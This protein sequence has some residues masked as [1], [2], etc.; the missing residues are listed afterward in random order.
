MH[1]VKGTPKSWSIWLGVLVLAS[2]ACVGADRPTACEA[3]KADWNAVA[4]RF[5]AT[6]SEFAAYIRAEPDTGREGALPV[7]AYARLMDQVIE[8]AAM[9]PPPPESLSDA[10]EFGLESLRQ[11][12][13]GVRSV[14]EGIEAASQERVAW[15]TDLI[16]QG[17]SLAAQ[18]AGLAVCEDLP[19]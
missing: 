16:E 8:E 4:D 2:T 7:Y 1:L 19:G 18:A 13:A 17:R 9:L 5:D 11:V 15:G 14:G 6:Y 10:Q 3:W 12:T